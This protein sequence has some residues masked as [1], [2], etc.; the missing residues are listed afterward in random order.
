MYQFNIVC[1]IVIGAILFFSK[2]Q[3][4]K[5]KTISSYNL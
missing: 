3:I 1:Y 4:F 5:V 2:L